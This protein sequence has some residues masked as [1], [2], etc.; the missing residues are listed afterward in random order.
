MNGTIDFQFSLPKG[1]SLSWYVQFG[2]QESFGKEL[3]ENA[4]IVPISLQLFP[5]YLVI[6]SRAK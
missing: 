6:A 5:L 1:E 3:N 4:Q 2:T